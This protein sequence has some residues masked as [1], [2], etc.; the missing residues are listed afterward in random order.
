M[1]NIDDKLIS[2]D[3]IEK[4]FVCNLSKCKGACC[5]EGDFGAPL[6]KEEIV[7]IDESLQHFQ[8]DLPERSQEYLKTNSFYNEYD[9]SQFDGTALH[10]DG[11][12]VFLTVDNG[13]SMCG[14]EKA[15]QEGK[16]ELRKP[17]SCHLY[18]IRVVL[19]G[20]IAYR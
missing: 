19:L 2:A 15:N 16:T 13:I 18:P 17:I 1:I 10:E 20:Q 12:C 5:W 7:I 11:A 14:I 3:V 6:T 9:K 8:E 4:N